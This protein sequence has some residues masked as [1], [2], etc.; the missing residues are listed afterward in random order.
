MN[1]TVPYQRALAAEA[2][3]AKGSA[4]TRFAAAGLVLST[5]QGLGWWFVATQQLTRWTQLLG[6]QALYAT[7]LHAPLTALLTALTVERE[8]RAR[9]GG[10]LWRPLTQPAR[11]AA[12]ATVVAGQLLGLNLALT[13]PMLLFGWAHGLHDAPVERILALGL[14]LWLCSLL[15]AALSLTLARYT[16]LYISV[17]L[18]LAWQVAGTLGS[19]SSAWSWQPW[20]WQVRAILPLLG[21]HA[22]GLALEPDSP[23]WSVNPVPPTLM[24][25][26]L[27]AAIAL[28]TALIP[29]R[30]EPAR[31]IRRRA[32]VGFAAP[33]ASTPAAVL[34]ADLILAPLHRGRPRPVSAMI[35][36]LR[37]TAVPPLVI[38]TVCSIVVVGTVWN[39]AY[40]RGLAAW[41]IMP[42]GTCL[43]ACLVW[44]TQQPA[45]RA[46]VLRATTRRLGGILLALSL[47]ALTVVVA[48]ILLTA[49]L[50]GGTDTSRFAFLL[51]IVG[52]A[53]LTLNL[54]LGTRYGAA[55]AIT[56]T[57]ITLVISI[58]FAGN[59]LADSP[60]WI[61]GILAWPTTA[62]TV[63]RTAITV[64]VSTLLL[65]TASVRWAKA[66]RRAART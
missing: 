2:V 29:A 12:R 65:V 32:A 62:N 39:D 9:E 41:L 18:A 14:V 61:I 44:A 10:T 66:L 6:W 19:E 58:V 8:R 47:A 15:P 64:A 48:V 13:A 51:W 11:Y 49:Q 24:S 53:W 21:I 37:H 52:S 17:G 56:T 34:H 23:I 16:G 33:V 40:V 20:T 55:S 30:P 27:A 31:H 38:A 42:L 26:A 35:L 54:W 59:T 22:N 50:R 1:G 45:W 46:V 5:L 4:S 25:L 36:S 60:L 7:A 3:R 63:P 57:L 43:L 28:C